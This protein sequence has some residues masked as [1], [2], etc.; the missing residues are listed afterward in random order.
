MSPQKPLRSIVGTF[1]ILTDLFLIGIPCIILSKVQIPL[2]KRVT[3][4]A[5]FAARIMYVV[6]VECAYVVV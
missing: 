5:A 3:T 1:D 4:I 2:E 6:L